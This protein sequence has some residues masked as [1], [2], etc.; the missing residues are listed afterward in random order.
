MVRSLQGREPVNLDILP[1]NALRDGLTLG[2]MAPAIIAVV[3]LPLLVA[4]GAALVLLPRKN[5]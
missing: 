5:L 2:S 1:K 3:L 4:L